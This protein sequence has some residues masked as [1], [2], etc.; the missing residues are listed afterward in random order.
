MLGYEMSQ[1]VRDARLPGIDECAESMYVK[2]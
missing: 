2:N 1:V